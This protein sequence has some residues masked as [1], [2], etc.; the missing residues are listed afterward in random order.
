MKKFLITG[1]KRSGTTFIS[2][3]LNTNENIACIEYKLMSLNDIRTVR[4]LNLYNSNTIDNLLHFEIKPPLI[5]SIGVKKEYLINNFLRNLSNHYKVNY[6]G[7]KQT[8][9]NLNQIKEAIKFGFKVIITKRNLEKVYTSQV[10]RFQINPFLIARNIKGYIK[11]INNFSF[12]SDILANILIIDFNNL[13]DKKEQVIKQLS[14]FLGTEI[15]NYEKL[16]YSFNK[17]LIFSERNTSFY[18]DYKLNQK[19]LD[20]I[21]FIKGKKN[22]YFFLNL[23]FEIIEKLKKN[24]KTIVTS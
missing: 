6:V 10:N 7:F 5:D 3:L 18:L 16:Y 23:F 9:L 14:N 13:K 17:G 19:D 8:E 20:L 21:K 4:D 11:E 22:F 24:F 12:E 2:S 1:F 15:K